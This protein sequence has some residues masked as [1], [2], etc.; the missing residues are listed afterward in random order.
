[1]RSITFPRPHFK[2][3][4]PTGNQTRTL[5]KYID[6]GGDMSIYGDSG[7]YEQLENWLCEY[8]DVNYTIL[9]NTG[10]S[11]LNSAY[12][13][14]GV[15]RGDEVIV[16]TYTFLAT[17]TPLL[18]IGAVPVFADA[19]PLTGNVSPEDIE[20]KITDKTKAVA[21]T[22]MWGVACDM[23]KIM[24]IANKH[25]LKVV[26]DCSHAH[27][28]RYKGKLLGTYGHVACFSIGAKKTLTSGEG[29]FLIT[30]D[31]EIYVRS[32]L[33]GHFEVRAEDAIDRLKEEGF[34][35]LHDRYA[36]YHTGFGENYR[37]HPY[38][39]VMS[40]ALVSSGEIFDLIKKRSESLRYFTEQLDKVRFVSAP[41]LH[42]GYFDGAMYGYKGKVH[43]EKLNIP[44]KDAVGMLKELNMEIKLPDSEPLHRKPLFNHLQ[45]LG[46]SY[47]RPAVSE[48]QYPGAEEYFD[49]R[50]SLPTFSQG[51]GLDRPLINEYIALLL[52]FEKEYGL[53]NR[54]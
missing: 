20:R 5:K 12:V 29:G 13:G 44:V 4:K 48:G 3:G 9:T 37:M 31:P 26:E 36:G 50:I 51:I 32:N 28:T 47:D 42:E 34:Q 46:I 39:A 54:P 7:I 35:D 53:N 21:V 45:D 11:A 19:D 14:I 15:Q 22:H 18:R 10:T 16:P 24:T 17:V 43:Q 2:W 23:E 1:M 49:G 6:E 25:N 41:V 40:H 38:S 33:L 8:Y 27:F 52:D 30:D